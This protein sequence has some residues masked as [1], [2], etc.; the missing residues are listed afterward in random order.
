MKGLVL[1]TGTQRA[2][3]QFLKRPS[4][5]LLLVGPAG[6]GKAA[7]AGSVAARVL[8]IEENLLD[9][10]PY[11]HRVQ[12]QDA[13]QISIEAIRGVI[14]FMTLKTP[15]Y[16][17]G[18]VSRVIIIQDAQLLTVQAQNALLKMVE[19][20]PDGTLLILTADSAQSLLPT[21]RSRAR[22]LQVQSPDSDML[23]AHFKENGF[24]QQDIEKA[25]L[26]SGGLPGLMQALLTQSTG[27][28]LMAASAIAR[29]LLQ[30]TAFERLIAAEELG[31][32][33]QLALDTLL[34]LS[35]MANIALQQA[36]KTASAR[37]WHKVFEASHVAHQ[38]IAGNAQPKLALLNFVL[39]I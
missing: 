8:Q 3:E 25:L 35:R 14:H 30:K 29:D 23:R 12:P 10:Y 15:N 34:I 5:A 26:M 19:E 2:V 17:P 21:V 1:S 27:H 6:S 24:I 7:L 36:D 4:H 33:R 20:P 16:T 11:L 38:Q 9:T 13:K 31:K 32:E 39:A 22:Q 37:Q 18:S 28:P